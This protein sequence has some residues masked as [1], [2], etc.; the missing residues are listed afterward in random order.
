MLE[1]QIVLPVHNMEVYV[2]RR[3]PAPLIF[4]LGAGLK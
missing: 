4:E 2:R 3:G 1:G